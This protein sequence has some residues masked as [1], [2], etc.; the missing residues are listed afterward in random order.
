[1][2][3]AGFI[4]LTPPGTVTLQTSHRNVMRAVFGISSSEF[5]LL[6]RVG[7]A[8]ETRGILVVV[9]TKSLQTELK[10]TLEFFQA[11]PPH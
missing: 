2:I 11:L 1:M 3:Q 9:S 8:K 10:S 4:E 7:A 6:I 5:L